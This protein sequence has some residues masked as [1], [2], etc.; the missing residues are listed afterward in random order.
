[1]ARSSSSAD[2]LQPARGA[3]RPAPRG[4]HRSPPASAVDA[5]PP[6]AGASRG[7]GT[8]RCRPA[9]R[10]RPPPWAVRSAGLGADVEHREVTGTLPATAEHRDDV[11]SVAEAVRRDR[12]HGGQADSF[13]RPRRRRFFTMA[14]P[15]RVRMRERN[16]CFLFRR[17]LLGWYVRFMDRPSRGCGAPADG[18]DGSTHGTRQLGSGPKWKMREPRAG[19]CDRRGCARERTRPRAPRA[20]APRG[21]PPAARPVRSVPLAPDPLMRPRTT[22]TAALPQRPQRARDRRAVAPGSAR[23]PGGFAD[24]DNSLRQATGPVYGPR[25][26]AGTTG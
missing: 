11:A 5:R 21:A 18:A 3:P 10:R 9:V 17:R 24:V 22:A 26:S 14:R 7:C 12:S 6:A 4:R 8:R 2:L 23:S 13:D 19:R 16:P 20:N 15:A 25:P 1:V